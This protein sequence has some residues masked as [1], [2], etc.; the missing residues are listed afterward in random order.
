MM[1]K[2]NGFTHVYY[3]IGIVGQSPS[4]PALKEW[5]IKKAQLIHKA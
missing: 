5:E 1:N 2:S 4:F 3:G